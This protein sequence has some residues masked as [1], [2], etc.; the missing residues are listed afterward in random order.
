[1]ERDNRGLCQCA[2][3]DVAEDGCGS[4]IVAFE[5]KALRTVCEDPAKATARFGDVVAV[6]LR[7]RLADIRSAQNIFELP[8]GA[9][10]VEEDLFRIDV[11]SQ[12]TMLWVQNSQ[13]PPTTETGKLDWTQVHRIKLVSIER[14]AR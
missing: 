1:M 12:E 11:G 10:R 14:R 6:L 9:P 7:R 4:M 2:I 13:S 3:V 8:A 5:S